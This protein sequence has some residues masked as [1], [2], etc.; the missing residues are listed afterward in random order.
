MLKELK[1]LDRIKT[2][3]EIYYKKEGNPWWEGRTI[4]STYDPA[5]GIITFVDG[6]E[7]DMTLLGDRNE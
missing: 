4:R 1:A 2:S 5:T 7:V 6:Y 3:E